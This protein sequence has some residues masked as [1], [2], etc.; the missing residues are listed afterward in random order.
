MADARLQPDCAGCLGSSTYLERP[1]RSALHL[2]HLWHGAFLHADGDWN[3]SAALE[4]ARDSAALPL[5][6]ISVATR[7]IR[8]DGH[9]VDA[10][11]N[12]HTPYASLLGHGDCAGRS[13]FLFV[14]EAEQPE[15]G[16]SGVDNV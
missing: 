13:A 4:A 11:H 3:V 7:D 12:R 16:S 9:G 10:E 15:G 5:H 8:A 6:G 1:L 2:C 14:L